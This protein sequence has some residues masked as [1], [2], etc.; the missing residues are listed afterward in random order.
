[1][2]NTKSK[3]WYAKKSKPVSNAK[4]SA[5]PADSSKEG[6]T[7]AKS[8]PSRQANKRNTRASPQ[9]QSYVVAKNEKNLNE[10]K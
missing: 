2:S 1:M 8:P 9:I 4:S 10:R 3:T 7:T 5:P 6:N